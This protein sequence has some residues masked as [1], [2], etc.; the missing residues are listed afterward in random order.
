MLRE[1]R[2]SPQGADALSR[3][4]A[5]RCLF[6]LLPLPLAARCTQETPPTPPLRVP[7]EELEGGVRVRAFVGKVP[8]EVRLED[9]VPKA[10]SLLCTHQGCEVSWIPEARRYACPCHEAL[11]NEEGVPIEGPASEPLRPLETRVEEGHAV[12]LPLI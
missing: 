9:G 3:R 7:L 1:G 11:F 6:A 8:V 12:I 2:T 5:M 4:S 10:R